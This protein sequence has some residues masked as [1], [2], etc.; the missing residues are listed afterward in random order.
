MSI[1]SDTR[2]RLQASDAAKGRRVVA[3]IAAHNE[4]H[5]IG[6]A[7]TSLANQTRPPDEVIVVADRCTDRTA[8][9]AATFGAKVF[10]TTDNRYRKAGALNQ[11]LMAV[12]ENLNPSDQVLLM[13]AD[14][15]LHDRFIASA[16]RRLNTVDKGRRPVGAVGGV[17][18]ARDR[19]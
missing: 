7:L 11:A 8:E 13:D 15:V 1:A 14:T 6:A 17:F 3:V 12:F 5:A 19:R 4:E 10:E 18:L 9:I 16:E 2:P